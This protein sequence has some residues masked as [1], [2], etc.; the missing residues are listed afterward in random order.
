VIVLRLTLLM[1]LLAGAALAVGYPFYVD[2]T[3]AGEVGTWRVYDP[4]GG[5]RPVELTLPGGEAHAEL[6][7]EMVADGEPRLDGRA[8]LTVTAAVPGRTLLA[9]PLTFQGVAPSMTSPQSPERIYRQSAGTIEAGE[10]QGEGQSVLV[11]VARGDAEEVAIRQ[12]DLILGRAAPLDPRA[13]PIGFSLM[14]LAFVG[15]VLTFRG[16]PPASPGSTPPRQRWGRRAE[17]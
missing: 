1:L 7:V 13:Q 14:A 9:A 11:T 17:P 8:V 6:L 5:F 15:L 3:S 16:R 4:Q 12:V 2:G 10:G